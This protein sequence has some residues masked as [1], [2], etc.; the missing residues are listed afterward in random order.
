MKTKVLAMYL[1][2]YHEIPENNEWWGEGFTE[3]TNVKTGEPLF[4]GHY[5]PRIPLNNNYYDLSNPNVM[6]NQ[7]NLAR[8]YGVDG[9]C[10][11]HY[12]FNGK[13]L[14]ERPVEQLLQYD[15]TPIDYCLCWANESWTKTW[16]GLDGAKDVLISQVYGD[17]KDWE[18]HFSYYLQFFKKRNYIKYDNKPVLCIYNPHVIEKYNE[19][20]VYWDKL[21]KNNG[22][23]GIY[24]ICARRFP[25]F[26]D[27]YVADS[28][29]DFEPFATKACID[30]TEEELF[31]NRKIG[32][33][34]DNMYSY[35]NSYDCEAICKRITEKYCGSGDTHLLGMFV[36]WDNT[37]RR[38]LNPTGIFENMTPEIFEKYFRIQ[39]Q[40][41]VTLRKSFIFINAWNE[42]GEGT[43]LEPDSKYGYKFLEAIKKVRNEVNVHEN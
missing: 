34:D 19:M 4:E 20:I 16:D 38:G 42:W 7:M 13:K 30:G 3:W 25:T 29:Y 1:P 41:S 31:Q 18:N 8:E 10:I 11:Y 32:N 9:F 36:G 15:E 21:A 43:Y 5:Q 26:D 6:L 37:A 24:I 27:D 35:Y 39:Y 40:K 12:W 14:L 28:Y 2:Q 22:F 17:V 23:D 33:R